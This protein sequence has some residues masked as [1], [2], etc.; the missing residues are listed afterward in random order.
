MAKLEVQA[1]SWYENAGLMG[2]DEQNIN[3]VIMATC[4]IGTMPIMFVFLY[5]QKYIVKGMTVGAVKG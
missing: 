1:K 3:S 2:N 5:L 4:I